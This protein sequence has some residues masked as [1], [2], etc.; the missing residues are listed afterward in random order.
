SENTIQFEKERKGNK[1]SK[2]SL[3]K[4]TPRISMPSIKSKMDIT[5]LVAFNLAGNK[6][7]LLADSIGGL[8]EIGANTSDRIIDAFGGTGAFLHYLKDM[9]LD[10]PMILNEFEPLRYITY[11]Q[12]KDNPLSVSF[13][14]NL[15]FTSYL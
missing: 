12:V 7:E 10:K 8:V 5:D 4:E 6:A 11:K 13:L 1:T 14:L 9:G 15:L 3:L 2:S